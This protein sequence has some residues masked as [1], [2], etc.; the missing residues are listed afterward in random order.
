MAPGRFITFEG[1]EGAGKST[2]VA[3]LVDYLKGAGRH[4]VQTRE[5]GGSPAAERVRDLLLRDGRS[6]TAMSEAL[7]HYAARAEHLRETIRP[8]LARGEWVICDRFS[9]STMA[10]QGY[11]QGLDRAIIAE[12]DTWV[13]GDEH[14]DLTLILDVPAEVGRTRA[15][16]RLQDADRYE[17][18]PT[19]FH[20]RVRD[21][22]LAIARA[23]PGRCVVL[24]ATGSADTVHAAVVAAVADRLGSG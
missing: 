7:L 3:R 2:Q 21:G 24:D 16:A 9:D 8:A 22:F 6:W 4:V 11:G 1:G 12:L 5:P 13:V 15:D 19:D 17:R 18:M 10:Y 14:P 23:A 20:A